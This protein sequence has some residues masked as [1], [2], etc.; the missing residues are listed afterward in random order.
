MISSER[1]VERVR[2][3][4]IPSIGRLITLLESRSDGAVELLPELYEAG[5]RARLIGVTG[6]P[7]S[8]KS[9]LVSALA[10]ELRSRDQTVGVVAVD[11]SS[12]LTGGSIL[13]DR[14]RMQEHALDPGIFV[15]SMSSR[16]ALGGVSRATVD[17]VTVLDASG[18]DVVIVETVGAGQD[19]VE[20]MRTVHTTAVV[21]VPGMGDDIQAIKAGLLE[22]AD[23]HV[24]NKG[25]RPETNRTVL[26]LK[27]MLALAR[28]PAA[29]Q[30]DV[31]VLTT[32][33]TDGT[34]IP[35]LVD[36]LES[37][38]AWLE[39]SGELQ[40]RER[41]AA[42]ARLTTLAQELLLEELEQ[43]AAG[44]AFEAAV[45]EVYHRRTD[46]RTAARQLIRAV[47]T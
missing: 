25:D 28:R 9:T 41:Q 36:A 12:S 13:G 4:H 5:G 34:G 11:P 15:R 19:E 35:E 30:W 27:G 29:D 32:V 26:E 3:G 24:V 44:L 1:L 31:P 22:I 45:E 14:I 2:Q 7:G 23:L 20:I 18:R 42:A 33:A 47:A 46:P 39:R 21:S 10:R 43:P 17:A 6:S 8:G 37:H 38:R 40:R 16:G